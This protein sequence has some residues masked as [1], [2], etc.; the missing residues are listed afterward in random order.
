MGVSFSFFGLVY[1]A[2]DAKPMSQIFRS[3]F[4]SKLGCHPSLWSP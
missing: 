3:S 4:F 2:L 1:A